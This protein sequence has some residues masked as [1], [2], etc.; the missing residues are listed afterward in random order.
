LKAGFTDEGRRFM[1][2]KGQQYALHLYVP[3]K[4]EEAK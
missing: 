2:P 3:T 1:G 4:D